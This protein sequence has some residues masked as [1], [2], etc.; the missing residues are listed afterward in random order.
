MKKL[1]LILAT[2]FAFTSAHAQDDEIR[3]RFGIK[4]APN[5]SWIRS[6]TKGLEG[7]GNRFG[8]SIGLMAEFPMGP[9]GN[10]RF[11]TGLFLTTIGGKIASAANADSAGISMQIVNRQTMNLRFVEL[12]LTIKLMTNEIGYMRYFG[13]IGLMGGVNVRARADAETITTTNG[14]TRTDSENDIDIQDNIRAI[15]AALVIGG[16]MEYN[17]SGQTSA[18][19]GITYNNSIINVLEKEAIPG[20]DSPKLFAEYLELTLG[21]FF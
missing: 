8:Y 19:I 10:Y 5:L 9:T 16:G 11:A 7:D 20:F 2:V 18:L 1:F 3:T 12:P 14:V 13:T 21:V 4:V 17:F 15:R 6:D